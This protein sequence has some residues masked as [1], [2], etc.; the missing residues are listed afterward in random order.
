MKYIV[1]YNPHAGDGWNDEKRSAAEKSIGGECSFCDMTKTDYAS[2]F[3]KMTDGERLVLI[4]GDGTLNRFINDTKNLK[5]PEHIL[6]LAGGSG[7][8]FL[9]DICGS[10]TSDKPIDVDKYIKN[11]PTVTV[12][13][14][15]E[16]FLNGIG[17]GIDGYCCRV[18]DEIKEKAQKK[19]NYTAIAIKGVLFHFKPSDAVVTVDG[20]RREYKN[21]WLAPTMNGRYY[22]G[23]MIPT[24]EQNRL[25]DGTLSLL[26]WHGKGKLKTLSVFPSIFKGELVS[27]GEMCEVLT[28][29]EIEVEFSAPTDLQIDGETVKNVTHYAA[30]SYGGEKADALSTS[31]GAALA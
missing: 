2:L 29:R 11:L 20:A 16:L 22:G 21:V 13:G 15:E 5:L 14:K 12:N 18:G 28:G 3:G 4:G 23:G 1:L 6:Y 19:P 7:N 9:H 10:Q 30:R 25:G 8:D 17:Y 27:L 24:P 26:V 31:S